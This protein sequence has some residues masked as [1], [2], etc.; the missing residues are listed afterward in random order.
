MS[1]ILWKSTALAALV[2]AG[3]MSPA[4]AAGRVGWV[5]ANQPNASGQYTPPSA[6]SYNSTGG[7]ITVTPI[8]TGAYKVTFAGLHSNTGTDDVQVTAYNTTGF[9]TAGQWSYYHGQVNANVNCYD[10]MDNPANTQFDLLYQERTGIFGTGTKGIAFVY[11]NSPT[12]ASYT[13]DT[14]YQYN[15]TGG[16]NTIIRNSEGCIRSPSPGSPA[17]TAISR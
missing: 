1:S 5:W 12:S 3:S 11:A 15:S 17:R 14:A 4:Q 13:P 2:A 7:A 6:Y 9:C 8:A 10:A 16:T